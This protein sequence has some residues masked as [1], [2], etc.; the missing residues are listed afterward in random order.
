H[1]GLEPSV[2]LLDLLVVPEKRRYGF[3]EF[4]DHRAF[5]YSCRFTVL[6]HYLAVDDHGFHGGSVFGVNEMLA[7][8][9][10][11]CEIERRRVEHDQVSFLSWRKR[12]DVIL[13]HTAACAAHRCT[14]EDFH[15]GRPRAPVRGR[16]SVKQRGRADH[17]K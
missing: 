2:G 17:I 12:T 15:W 14:P 11:R 7:R 4:I 6:D 13:H 1:E 10:E 9:A 5:V 16:D 8:V 3:T